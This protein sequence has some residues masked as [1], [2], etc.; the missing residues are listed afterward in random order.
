MLSSQKID[1]LLFTGDIIDTQHYNYEDLKSLDFK[2]VKKY[3][4]LGN[5]EFY[6]GSKI[7]E[8]VADLG[9]EILRGE[10]TGF[11]EINIIGIDDQQGSDGTDWLKNNLKHNLIDKEKFNILLYHRPTEVRVAKESAIDLMLTGHTHGG[12]IFPITLIL[13]L[14]YD[15]P[16]GLVQLDNFYLYTS[17]GAGL[18]GPKMRLGTSN[19]ITVFHLYPQK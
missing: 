4:S 10:K 19:E 16:Q 11:D 8:I 1:A 7:L 15:F 6:H 9:Y 3:F 18:W 13:K 5:H 14:I 17:D 12:Q 2:G